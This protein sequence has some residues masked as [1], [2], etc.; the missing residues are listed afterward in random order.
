MTFGKLNNHHCSP[1]SANT[2]A[3]KKKR[4]DGKKTKKER[5]AKPKAQA[6]MLKEQNN[7]SRRANEMKTNYKLPSSKPSSKN[8]VDQTFGLHTLATRHAL[9][10]ANGV[11]LYRPRQTNYP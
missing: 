6:Q 8:I 4:S 2:F 1:S 11:K 9:K 3:T 7:K 5:K 10:P